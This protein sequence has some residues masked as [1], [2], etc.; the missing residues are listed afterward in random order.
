MVGPVPVP[1]PV[2]L[3]GPLTSVCYAASCLSRVDLCTREDDWPV[4]IQRGTALHWVTLGP[5]GAAFGL[6]GKYDVGSIKKCVI[7]F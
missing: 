4:W 3:R 7:I 2:S 1:G 5:S 6:R